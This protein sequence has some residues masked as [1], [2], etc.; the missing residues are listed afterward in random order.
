MENDNQY[1]TYIWQILTMVADL[2]VRDHDLRKEIE[3]LA[4]YLSSLPVIVVNMM[5]LSYSK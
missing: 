5:K 3:I 4:K 2:D 1:F